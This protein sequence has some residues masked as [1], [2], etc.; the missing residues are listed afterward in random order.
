MR[1]VIALLGTPNH[2]RETR[3][4]FNDL[5][6]RMPTRYVHL[7]DPTRI[8]KGATDT[9]RPRGVVRPTPAVRMEIVDRRTD[10]QREFMTSLVNELGGL[11]MDLGMQALEYTV[12]MTEAGRW[13]PGRDTNVSV[14]ID[15]LKSKIAELKQAARVSNVPLRTGQEVRIADSLPADHRPHYYAVGDGPEDIKF[16]R[17]KR[18]NKAGVFFI[19]AQASDEFHPVRNAATRRSILAAIEDLTPAVCMSN[20]GQLIGSCG[21]CHRTLTDANSRA[22]GIG[23]ECAGKL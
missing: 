20:Y 14:W 2:D 5:T 3:T 11:D 23:P 22:M 19:E 16:Y 12:R 21:R 10:G 9:P 6:A 15:R 13:E 8:V 18:G 1:D 17:I 7:T 4:D